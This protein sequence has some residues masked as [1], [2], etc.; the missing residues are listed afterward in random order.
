MSY[1]KRFPIDTLK[2]DR[3]FTSGL[4]GDADDASIVGAIIAMAHSLRLRVTAEGV[5]TE[6][7]LRFLRELGCEEA[8]GYLFS[9]PLPAE[10]FETW[11]DNEPTGTL[12]L[13]SE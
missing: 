10:L 2:I 6:S 5:E 4:P 7:Q 8:Q 12:A 9:K 3:S 11:L 13:A 1:L